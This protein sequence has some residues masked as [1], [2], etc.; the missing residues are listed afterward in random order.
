MVKLSKCLD[1]RFKR[2]PQILNSSP[3]IIHPT[4]FHD[5]FIFYLLFFFFCEYPCLLFWFLIFHFFGFM[6][7]IVVLNSSAKWVR[8]SKRFWLRTERFLVVLTIFFLTHSIQFLKSL[9]LSS[10]FFLFFIALYL[11]NIL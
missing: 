3:D 7:K 2:R 6:Y 5:T 1:L 4:L 9:D 8:T 10:L 11:N